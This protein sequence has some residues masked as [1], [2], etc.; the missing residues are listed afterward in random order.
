MKCHDCE[1]EV[2]R[3]QRLLED[4]HRHMAR[5]KARIVELEAIVE[6]EALA[7]LAEA[8]LRLVNVE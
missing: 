8:K 1:E 6:S 7:Q 4:R 3:L 2:T 5:Y